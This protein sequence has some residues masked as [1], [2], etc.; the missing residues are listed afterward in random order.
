[1]FQGPMMLL[2]G[3]ADPFFA[4]VQLLLHMDGS[5]GST[6]FTD[7][8]SAARTLTANGNAQISTA[9]SQF[10]GASGLFDGNGDY[11]A[12]PS[13][14]ALTAAGDFTL[15]FWIRPTTWPTTNTHVLFAGSFVIQ[16]DNANLIVF[17]GATRSFGSLP[18]TGVWTHVAVTRSGMGTNNCKGFLNGTQSMQWTQTSTTLFTLSSATIGGRVSPAIWFNGH[19]DEWRWTVGTARYTSSFTVPTQPFPDF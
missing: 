2:A 1:M 14:A 15:E 11:V 13:N 17:D 12:V 6:T 7:S 18:S 8:S 10:G 9:Q 3:A 4:N 19:I 16:R 5:N